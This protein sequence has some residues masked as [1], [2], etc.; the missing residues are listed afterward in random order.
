MPGA[1]RCDS[2]QRT[3]PFWPHDPSEV[4]TFSHRDERYAL[5]Y[6]ETRCG[7]FDLLW[8]GP[9]IFTAPK[10]DDG[11][12]QAWT[13][14]TSLQSG[15]F[16][17][18]PPNGTPAPSPAPTHTRAVTIEVPN[19]APQAKALNGSWKP[20]ALAIGFVIAGSVGTWLFMEARV[21]TVGATSYERGEAAGRESGLEEGREIGYTSGYSS[22]RSTGYSN[23]F[24]KGRT[25]GFKKGRTEG[26]DE[27]W[28]KGFDKGWND[29]CT[30][31]FNSLQTDRI[32]GRGPGFFGSYR[33]FD[34]SVCN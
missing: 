16:D 18:P 15:S 26:F 5:G 33:Y 31:F 9:P 2:C 12:G 4:L 7:V 11:W 10:T 25:E 14:Y 6:G 22:G 28:I 34:R 17:D 20:F 1:A 8:G 24:K 19:P 32:Y 27:G 23:G 30:S 13:K 29:R 3:L 21:E